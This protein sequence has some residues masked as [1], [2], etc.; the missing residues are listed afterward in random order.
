MLKKGVPYLSAIA[1]ISFV[2]SVSGANVL[3]IY[4]RFVDLKTGEIENRMINKNS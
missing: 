4:V 1:K 3:S 2:V